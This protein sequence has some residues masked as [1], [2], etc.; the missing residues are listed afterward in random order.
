[1]TDRSSKDIVRAFLDAARDGDMASAGRLLHPEVQVI[2][3]DSLPFGGVVSGLEGFTRLVRR[4]FTTFNNTAVNIDE[5]IAEGDT[6]V[7]L[8]TMTG[9]SKA[10]GETFAMP[11]SE[12][13][14]L[15]DGLITEIR[16]F[17]HDTQKINALAAGSAESLS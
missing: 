3:A 15:R 6:V 2:E 16:P 1:M 7:V 8:A 14:R 4:V 10:S 5:Y 13:W 12:I 9:Q 17:Y 11:I